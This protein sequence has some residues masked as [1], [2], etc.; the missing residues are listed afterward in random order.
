M[1]CRALP[2]R[3]VQ[4]AAQAALAARGLQPRRLLRIP[5]HKRQLRV[6]GAE[7]RDSS[8][9]AVAGEPRGAAAGAA[10]E[11]VR[12]ATLASVYSA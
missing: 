4:G 3:S 10:A 7:Q 8:A 1:L 12:S 9:A 5:P 6:A 2:L 11:M